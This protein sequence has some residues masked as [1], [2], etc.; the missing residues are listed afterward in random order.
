MKKLFKIV[1]LI[2]IVGSASLYFRCR[3]D[4][5][6]APDYEYPF[7]EEGRWY[8]EEIQVTLVFSV[9]NFAREDSVIIIDGNEIECHCGWEIGSPHLYLICHET[10]DGVCY[11]GQDLYVWEF[12][13]VTESEL[14]LKNHDSE[15]VFTFIRIDS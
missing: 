10:I 4:Y 7:P 15:E 2:L 11:Q 1:I 9:I 8:C 3:T 6:T 5:V 13:D 14:I 12:V